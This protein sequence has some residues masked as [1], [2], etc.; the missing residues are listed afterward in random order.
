MGIEVNLEECVGCGNCTPACPFGLIE[1]VRGKARIKDGCTLCGACVDACGYYAI[2][3][4]TPQKTTANSDSSRG[5]WVF[6]E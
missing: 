1:I 5:V 6:A 4:E 2:T 3:I